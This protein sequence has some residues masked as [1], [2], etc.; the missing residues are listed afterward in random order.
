MSA[1]EFCT[2]FNALVCSLIV[3][4]LMFYQREDARHRPAISLLAYLLVLGWVSVPL[5]FLF[6]LSTSPHWLLVVGNLIFCALLLRHKGNL[7]R[8]ID[9]LR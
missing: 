2:L 3:I 4:T 6:G 1:D 5:R 8:L 9:F 7:A